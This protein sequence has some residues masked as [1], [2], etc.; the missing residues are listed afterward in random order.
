MTATPVDL[1]LVR[2]LASLLDD[3]G[4]TE[5]EIA[6]GDF[7]IRMAKGHAPVVT[8]YAPGAVAGP[9]AAPAAA[10][11]PA[12]PAPAADPAGLVA[13]PM[14][15]TAYLAPQPGA[16]VFVREGDRVRAGQTLLIIEAM[17][18]MNPLPSPRDGTVTRIIVRDGQPVE[19]GE[20]LIV[21]E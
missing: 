12:A 19:F 2:Q 13:S 9:I 16:P 7:Q 14:V 11:A 6:S 3:K 21:V 18:V 8:A 17:K 4:L 15:G 1:E 5:L 10:S 20:H